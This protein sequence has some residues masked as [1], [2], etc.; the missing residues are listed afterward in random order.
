MVHAINLSFMIVPSELK[1][2]VALTIWLSK[3]HIYAYITST[4]QQ[5]MIIHEPIFS[6]DLIAQ[7]NKNLCSSVLGLAPK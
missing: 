6:M 1:H 7:N 3:K 4:G 2:Y 5:F